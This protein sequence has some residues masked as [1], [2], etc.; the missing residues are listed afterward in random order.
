MAYSQSYNWPSLFT[1][2]KTK[3]LTTEIVSNN[4]I[5]PSFETIRPLV[6]Q[7]TKKNYPLI[8]DLNLLT[9][10]NIVTRKQNK[11][12]PSKLN[13]IVQKPSQK[14]KQ[15]SR[16]LLR[17]P[18]KTLLKFQSRT[19][20]K[21]KQLNFQ[22]NQGFLTQRKRQRT[23]KILDFSSNKTVKM[24]KIARR[25]EFPV[26]K[27]SLT[28]K[29]STKPT[30][31]QSHNFLNFGLINNKQFSGIHNDFLTIKKKN[32]LNFD[33][34]T[35][36]YDQI[37]KKNNKQFQFNLNSPTRR[38]RKTKKNRKK[39][40]N[41]Q[42]TQ[43]K[44]KQ[45][46]F[47]NQTQ[48]QNQNQN[49]NVRI[50]PTVQPWSQNTQQPNQQTKS[51]QTLSQ[52]LNQSNKQITQKHERN[53][54]LSQQN[55]FNYE[56]TPKPYSNSKQKQKQNQPPQQ[57][58]QQETNSP[59]NPQL[60]NQNTQQH[61][62]HQ[63]T[64]SFQFQ[65]TLPLRTHTT[66]QPFN[67]NIQQPN[68]QTKSFQLQETNSQN[69]QQLNKPTK[70]FQT[71]QILPKQLN[72]S[73]Q[74]QNQKPNKPILFQNKKL[75][76]I[77]KP[78]RSTLRTQPTAQLNNHNTQQPNQQTKSFQTL[79]K[80]LNQSNLPKTQ[81]PDQNQT[82]P[83]PNQ[84]NLATTSNPIQIETQNQTQNKI[85]SLQNKRQETPNTKTQPTSLI[86][87]PT[88]HH[89]NHNTKQT[90]SFQFQQTLS[91]Q[92]SQFDLP[93]TK[94]PE[95]N[96]TIPQPNQLNRETTQTPIQIQIQ[97]QTQTQKQKQNI[98]IP[99]WN[100]TQSQ[101]Q[102][103]DHCQKKVHKQQTK[104]QTPKFQQNLLKANEVT[105]IFEDLCDEK[106]TEN[107]QEERIQLKKQYYEEQIFPHE[108]INYEESRFPKIS[109]EAA[110]TWEYPTNYPIRKYQFEITQTALFNNTLVVLPTGLGKTL[111]SAVVMYN[112]Y[113]WFPTG[114]ILFLA[115]FKPLV[116]QQIE[117]VINIVPFVSNDY[118]LLTGEIPI[119]TRQALWESKRVFF[120]TPQ[121]IVNDINNCYCPTDK[122]VCVIFDEIH[123][124]LGNYDY[125][126]LIKKI[127][128]QTNKFRVLGL[129][130]TPGT[131]TGQIQNVISNCL[132]SKIEVRL[133]KNKDLY[134]HIHQKELEVQKIE[135]ETN[136]GIKK[137]L[138]ILDPF[139][140]D[141][142]S[143]LFRSGVYFTDSIAL[144]NKGS[145]VKALTKM[146]IT[147]KN[148][149][150]LPLKNYQIG[151]YLGTFGKTLS[152]FHGRQLLT[153]Y[154]LKPFYQ[155]ILTKADNGDEKNHPVRN[156]K[157]R[158]NKKGRGKGRWKGKVEGK[159]TRITCK[160]E[161][162][163]KEKKTK[164]KRKKAKRKLNPVLMKKLTE[165]LPGLIEKENSHP[166]I[167]KL[168][169]LLNDHFQKFQNDTRV[170][171]FSSYRSSVVD[172]IEALSG[173][174]FLKVMP[175]VGHVQTAN[176]KGFTQREQK[177]ILQR[178]KKGIYNTLVSTCIGEEGFDI[179]EVD[180]IICYD[181]YIDPKR[182]FQRFGRT[183]RK[184]EGKIIVLM[185]KGK[186]ELIFEKTMN[187][188]N[189]INTCLIQSHNFI[190]Y[191]KNK[192]I[193]PENLQ[194][195]CIKKNFI[196]GNT[197]WIDD[198][199]P[200]KSPF[201]HYDPKNNNNTILNNQKTL[202]NDNDDDDLID[203]LFA[204][205]Q[206]EKNKQTQAN[207]HKSKYL[208]KTNQIFFDLNFKLPKS[209]K[210][211]EMSITKHIN[212]QKSL[213]SVYNFGH[214]IPTLILRSFISNISDI[215]DNLLNSSQSIPTTFEKKNRKRKRK[216]KEK[217]KKH[218][219]EEKKN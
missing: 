153:G 97:N 210:I 19:S 98:L 76:Q 172:I 96:Q 71:Q 8:D 193:V 129:T 112:Y 63:Q 177:I 51:F 43:Q 52:Q 94:K 15:K 110:K 90:K 4:E 174:S 197:S 36:K 140:S 201:R 60:K 151:M 9:N 65:Q 155:Y 163:N 133:D 26:N 148:L 205:T 57:R 157:R 101:V 93:I 219:K 12:S 67:Q 13:L 213:S 128:K 150:G 120:A 183:G 154:G 124:S 184:R 34:S 89:L 58:S 91:K 7:K 191:S 102:G 20:P 104:I 132:I 92:Q 31:R 144:T 123:H 88:V 86:L 44:E 138:E 56:T 107:E 156:N 25:L 66:V 106:E 38:K 62:Y 23:R 68:Q 173:I 194:T 158:T 139:I 64:K 137:S 113:R 127:L 166:K 206:N 59:N 179:G 145:L 72:F 125:V 35:N 192:R 131:T 182:T 196:I 28:Q 70:S 218:I 41:N 87:Q 49:F 77:P 165:I 209:E 5:F 75:H 14:K 47:T 45:N 61:E 189:K 204:Q 214:S 29:K 216:R 73:T 188:K 30:N 126:V 118:C 33:Q 160:K 82:V 10:E 176:C 74:K 178:F 39:K 171:I 2:N 79:S 11:R 24:K 115:P 152:L 95:Q 116:S 135:I 161:K 211:P 83:Q 100:Q 217:S 48:N 122:I 162:E 215:N 42:Q 119:K 146:R 105:S 141:N 84:L 6:I 46:S 195:T 181:V 175:F 111:I 134:Q 207:E 18:K 170:I 202:L 212:N 143:L 40:T 37:K 190:F 69:I 167:E 117:A 136:N 114:K 164:R 1:V 27:T 21:K 22:L 142:L 203:H 186:E 109:E 147:K 149:M 50:Q 200:I 16:S 3:K 53:R 169:A 78:F 159:A 168:K 187:Q 103:Q 80:Q 180:L 85:V 185:S 99:K 81:K 108:K 208:S 32:T 55:Q 121:T 198:K 130:A 17:T 54:A 199:Q